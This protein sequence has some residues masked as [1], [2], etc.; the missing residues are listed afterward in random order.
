MGRYDATRR[1]RPPAAARTV[2]AR[3]ALGWRPD[4]AGDPCFGDRYQGRRRSPI[5]SRSK[6]TCPVGGRRAG[7][8]HP[9]VTPP[10]EPASSRALLLATKRGG[11]ASGESGGDAACA[12]GKQKTKLTKNGKYKANKR[13]AP[14]PQTARHQCRSRICAEQRIILHTEVFVHECQVKML[15]CCCL[16]GV[17][18]SGG[19]CALD[20][21][22]D[23]FLERTQEQKPARRPPPSRGPGRPP[24]SVTLRCP[25]CLQLRR[26]AM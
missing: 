8:L 15:F 13:A 9:S 6:S 16:N 26:V 1:P 7:V 20:G 2:V 25:P 3:A 24:A 21:G 18:C 22:T 23:T 14:H 4:Q 5:M 17:L 11:R 12:C 19:L 10:R